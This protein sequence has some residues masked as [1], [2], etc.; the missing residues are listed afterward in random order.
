MAGGA[1][2]LSQ[3]DKLM[4]T[5]MCLTPIRKHIQYAWTSTF[6]PSFENS[7]CYLAQN[8]L[9]CVSLQHGALAANIQVFTSV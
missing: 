8:V 4:F 9:C 3:N 5:I 6:N 2:Q 1:L 7:G